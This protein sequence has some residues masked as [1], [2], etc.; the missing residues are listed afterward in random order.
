[1]EV[2]VLIGLVHVNLFFLKKVLEVW[3]VSREPGR[4]RE[5]QGMQNFVHENP[6]KII[7]GEGQ[8]ERIGGEVNRL[9]H[10]PSTRKL[11]S[12]GILNIRNISCNTL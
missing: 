5:V 12:V 9:D 4:F 11:P 10:R 6:S 3:S 1:V 2:P 8:I 7:F